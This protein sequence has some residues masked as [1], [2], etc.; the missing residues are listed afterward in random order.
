MIKNPSIVGFLSFWMLAM[1]M[2]F[3][4]TMPKV[5][6]SKQD[7]AVNFSQDF[8][9]LFSLGQKMLLADVFWVKTLLESDLSHY[10][11][12]DLNNWMYLRFN[13]I[14]NLD[15]KFYQNYLFGGLYLSIVKDDAKAGEA[16]LLDGV[17]IYPDDYYLN[18]QL[19]YIYAFEYQNFKKAVPYYAKIR[20]SPLRAFNFDSFYSK[21]LNQ[22]IGPEDALRHSIEALKNTPND[23]PIYEKLRKNIYTYKALIDLDCLNNQSKIDCDKI[24]FFGNSYLYKYGKYFAR[25]KLV[26][27]SISIRQQ[28]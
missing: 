25:E 16:L 14:K 9:V 1:V 21:L 15:P 24:D 4:I 6:V 19:G 3:Q 28:K 11:A 2:H 10:E 8:L 20:N 22:T 12:K 18:Y 5:E 23:T 13:S 17:K 27:V 26:K 7:S